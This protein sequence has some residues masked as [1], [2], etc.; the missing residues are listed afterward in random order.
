MKAWIIVDDRIN[1]RSAIFEEIIKA[2]SQQQAID[3]AKRTWAALSA[4]D[5]KKCDA[6]YVGFADVDEEG[7]IDYDTM[8]DIYTIK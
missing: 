4:D 5:K 2:N 3:I 8:T 6:Y 7:C 1:S